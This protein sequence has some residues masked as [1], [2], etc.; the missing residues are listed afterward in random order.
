MTMIYACFVLEAW[1]LSMSSYCTP[2]QMHLFGPTAY[3][4]WFFM[5]FHCC[6]ARRMMEVETRLS[7]YDE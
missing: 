1:E 6:N 3:V 5:C 2:V 7:S 4:E